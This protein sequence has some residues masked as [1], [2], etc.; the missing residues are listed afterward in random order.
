ML[1]A[2]LVFRPVYKTVLWGGRRLAPWRDDLPAGPVGESWEVA[3]HANGA[4]V[5]AEG[6][7]AGATLPSLVERFGT[8]LVGAGFSGKAFPL[9]VK[10]IDAADRLSVQVHPDGEDGKTECWILLADGGELYHGTRPGIDRAAFERA[11]AERRLAETLNRFEPCAGDVFFLAGRTVHA[12]GA[13]CLVYEVQQSSDVTFRVHD[14]DRVGADGKPRTLHVAEALQTIDF[15]ARGFGPRRPAWRDDR[16]TLVECA[17]FRLEERRGGGTVPLGDTCAI[18]TCLEGK[19]ELVAAGGRAR[20]APLRTV[21]VP[22]AAGRFEIEGAV[23]VVIA[24]PA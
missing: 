5:V 13:G 21:L 4:T 9:L 10:I 1:A 7:H 15:G 2:P 17:Y 11:L 16:R 20:L 24:R 6:A 19:G 18:V 14:W 3:A 8:E 23:R 12:L 22:A